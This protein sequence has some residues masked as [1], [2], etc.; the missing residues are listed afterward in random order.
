MSVTGCAIMQACSGVSG[1]A[2]PPARNMLSHANGTRD[3]SMM[4]APF[5]ATL[6]H[7]QSLRPD[8]GLRYSGLPRRF[9]KA[10]YAIDSTTL[11]LLANS[12]DWAKHRRR[13][14]AAKCHLRLDLQSFLPACA[15]IEEASHHDDTRAQQLCAGLKDGEIA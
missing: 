4:E 15:I 8:F 1:G 11:A 6:K 14:A 2:L 3:S 7:L 13:K 10:V 9:K 5:W 12:M